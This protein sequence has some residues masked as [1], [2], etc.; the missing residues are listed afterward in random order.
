MLTQQASTTAGEEASC[1]H[2]VG[3]Y[4]LMYHL[5]PLLLDDHYQQTACS[6]LLFFLMLQALTLDVLEELQ[7]VCVCVCTCM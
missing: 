6:R 1:S 3:P 4:L 5:L 2:W 7:P